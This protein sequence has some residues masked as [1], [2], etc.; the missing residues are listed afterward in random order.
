MKTR[1][2]IPYYVYSRCTIL[3]K[4]YYD[5]PT[6]L[7]EIERDIITAS[8]PPGDGMPRGNATG[9]PTSKKALKIMRA[10]ETTERQYN[11]LQDAFDELPDEFSRELID[12]NLFR[13]ISMDYVVVPM[14][15]RQ[16]KRVRSGFIRA[17][18]EKLEE[19]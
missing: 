2:R 5:I 13:G 6:R 17:L 18:A 15:E 3:A 11:A 14:S 4:A 10:K 7:R 19:I 12:K 16:K 1:G 8:A 9:D